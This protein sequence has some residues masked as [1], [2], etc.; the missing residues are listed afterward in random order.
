[1]INPGEFDEKIK[2]LALSRTDNIYQWNDS[3]SVWA[4]AA[5][6]NDNRPF[7]HHRPK[8]KSVKF[9]M[10]KCVLTLN[11]AV[12]WKGRHCFLTEIAEIDRMYFEVTAVMLEP[13]ICIAS[14]LNVGLNSLNRPVAGIESKLTF[15]GLLI[16]T[17]AKKSQE[18]PM[19]MVELRYRLTVPKEIELKAG[20][21]VEIEGI[22]YEVWTPRCISDYS[23]EYEIR[24]RRD[25]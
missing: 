12:L 17:Y 19:S 13:K 4:K 2:I 1:M 3:V 15:P 7:P 25:A 22:H 24:M 20:E 6:L 11:N 9:T 21:N 10:R 23:N 14:K 18:K 8:A 16:E 5:Q